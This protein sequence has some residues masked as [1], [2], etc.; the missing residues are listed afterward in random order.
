MHWISS[1]EVD[2]PR[3][4]YIEWSKSEREKQIPS[5]DTYI[6]NLGRWYWWTSLQGSKG[7][8]GIE[9]W[10]RRGQDEWR[11]WHWTCPLP[12][13]SMYRVQA[14]SVSQTGASGDLLCDSGRSHPV[15]WDDPEGWDGGGWEGHSRGTGRVC[16]CG[17]LR[18]MHGRNQHIIVKQL[19][20]D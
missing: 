5:I 16:T 10:G 15:L 8:T 9:K 14:C 18:L 19:S 2:E 17:W 3:A 13:A 6:W 1:N 4:H 7:D 12:R 20:V 11:E